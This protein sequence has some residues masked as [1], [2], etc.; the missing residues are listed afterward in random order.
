MVS[1]TSLPGS[2]SF[3][4]W[5][6]NKKGKP[7]LSH[8]FFE[9]QTQLELRFARSGVTVEISATC[10]YLGIWLYLDGIGTPQA[11][12]LELNGC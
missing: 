6:L 12:C 11:Q 5:N 1:L 9:K 10:R 4:A 7:P 2:D 3:D 8:F